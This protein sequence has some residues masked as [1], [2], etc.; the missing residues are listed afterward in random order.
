[1]VRILEETAPKSLEKAVNEFLETIPTEGVS[2]QFTATSH[3]ADG[4]MQDFFQAY[5]IY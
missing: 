1:M 4:E 5:I 2:I 3:V